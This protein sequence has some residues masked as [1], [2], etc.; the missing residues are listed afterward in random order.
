MVYHNCKIVRYP[1]GVSDILI[2]SRPIFPDC[3][4]KK[5]ESLEDFSDAIAKYM[6]TVQEYKSF[7][8]SVRRAKSRVRQIALSND[9][10][11]F[12]TLTLDPKKIDRFDMTKIVKDMRIWL[13]NRVRRKGLKYILVPERHDKGGIHFHGFFNDALDVVPSGHYDKSGHVIYNLPDWTYGFTTAIELYGDYPV[14]VAY[15]CKYIGKQGC[16]P[17]GRWYY[18]GGDLREPDSFVC[19]MPLDFNLDGYAFDVP[20]SSV[21]LLHDDGSKIGEVLECASYLSVVL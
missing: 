6:L 13:D 15:V 10:K 14:A 7:D 20:G 18:S 1:C 12:V 2:S 3:K 9:F 17:A 11:F 16:K 4:P 21:Q 5:S 19:T 8:R